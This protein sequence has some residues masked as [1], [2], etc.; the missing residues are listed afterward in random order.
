MLE[1]LVS[2]SRYATL[3]KNLRG[4][5]IVDP[6]DELVPNILRWLSRRFRYRL[7]GVPPKVLEGLRSRGASHH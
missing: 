1:L 5:L 6:D 4:V 7:V 3:V 2:F